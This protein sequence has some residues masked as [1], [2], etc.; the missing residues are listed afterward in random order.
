MSDESPAVASALTT[1][2]A[3]APARDLVSYV[4]HAI[5]APDGR[6]RLLVVDAGGGGALAVAVARFGYEVTAVEDSPQARADTVSAAARVGVA[7]DVIDMPSS[8][9]GMTFPL[10]HMHAA[11]VVQH[12]R[13]RARTEEIAL[14]RAVRDTL[15]DRG[16]LIVAADPANADPVCVVRE[17]G[18][19]VTRVHAH[20]G[21]AAAG[22]A[23]TGTRLIATPA[24]VAPSDLALGVHRAVSESASVLNLLWSPDEVDLLEP[25]LDEIWSPALQAGELATAARE[26]ALND[27]WGSARAAA[28]LSLFF[29]VELSEDRI[30]LGAGATGLLHD[31]APL[32]RCGAVVTTPL[33]HRDFPLWA[34]AHGAHVE[35]VDDLAGEDVLEAIAQLEAP[36]VLVDRPSATGAIPPLD[37]VARLCRETRRRGGV[38]I[39][40]E[41]Y[42]A[43]FAGSD[44]AV[45]LVGACDSM[46]VI[47]SLSKAYCCGGLRV[48]FAIA[49]RA[50]AA[51]LRRVVT[52]LQVSPI[53][54]AMGLRLIEAGDIFVKLRRRIASARQEMS[55]ALARGG[56]AIAAGAD[57][58]PWA[59]VDDPAQTIEIALSTRGIVAKRL[60]PFTAR[61]SGARWL[62]LAVPLSSER[63]GRFHRALTMP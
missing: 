23:V 41:A 32:A 5:G 45:A 47:R 49:G 26:Y 6:P 55:D 56:I 1:T 36:V 25:T 58:P 53:A 19:E 20:L 38:V 11:I 39:V 37:A 52:P 31:L 34:V 8:T 54:L 18:F 59:L 22:A 51:V 33:V 61:A 13:R 7:I 4:C 60:V 62:R 40:D 3:G 35:C 50:A 2:D 14:L 30:V 43:Y 17:A 12:G 42:M 44:S 29:G 16:V 15:V 27:P 63:M 24:P 46:I 28:P 57:A 9:L 48:G 21:G 10:D